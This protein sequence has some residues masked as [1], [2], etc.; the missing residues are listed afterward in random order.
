MKSQSSRSPRSSLKFPGPQPLLFHI[1]ALCLNNPQSS[2]RVFSL[3][4][5]VLKPLPSDCQS[6]PEGSLWN[7]FSLLSVKALSNQLPVSISPYLSAQYLLPAN[8]FF[9]TV[10]QSP[11]PTVLFLS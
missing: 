10:Q 7:S 3:F 11:Y 4:P 6:F 5:Q 2:Y 9:C 1:S 8:L